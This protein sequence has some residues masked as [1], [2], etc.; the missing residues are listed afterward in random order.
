VYVQALVS[1]RGSGFAPGGVGAQC[2]GDDGSAGGLRLF[3]LSIKGE[4]DGEMEA[5]AMRKDWEEIA[6]L[7]RESSDPRWRYRASAELGM[8]AFY[9]GDLGTARKN[10]GGALVAATQA[11]DVGGQ[12]KYLYAIGIGLSMSRMSSEAVP[13]LDK[14]IALSHA[15][16][17]APYPFMVY[18]AKA[19][20]LAAQGQVQEA[21][22]IIGGIL[23][24]ARQ[25]KAA[26]YEAI[27]LTT[28]ARVESIQGNVNDAVRDLSRAIQLCETGGYTRALIESRLALA[29]VYRSTGDLQRAEA[30]LISATAATQKNGLF[31]TGN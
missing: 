11:H 24:S 19:E 12:V 2:G 10:I 21:K 23:D 6:R 5:V 29:D 17:G 14:A 15:T 30:L 25:R 27:I 8:A 4:I 26:F 9:A 18:L 7:A 3:C 28:V 20:A 22:K 31:A 13:Y 1:L 16:P